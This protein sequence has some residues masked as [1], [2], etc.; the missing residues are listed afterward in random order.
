MMELFVQFHAFLFVYSCVEP[1][2]IPP[3]I[4]FYQ[5]LRKNHARGLDQIFLIG[6]KSDLVTSDTHSIGNRNSDANSENIKLTGQS[7]HI[8][9]IDQ[10]VELFESNQEFPLSQI[11]SI[12]C[13]LSELRKKSKSVFEV[14]LRSPESDENAKRILNSLVYECVPEPLRPKKK[15]WYEYCCQIV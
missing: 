3:L 7:T 11:Q 9:E 2:S 14:S 1:S 15:H 8:D 5:N 6:L 13:L 12:E 4:R 10:L